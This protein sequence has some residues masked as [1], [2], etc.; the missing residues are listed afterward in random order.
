MTIR[1]W[2]GCSG[3]DEAAFHVATAF[4]RIPLK[5]ARELKNFPPRAKCT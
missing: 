2:P 3:G 1:S 5:L 4:D